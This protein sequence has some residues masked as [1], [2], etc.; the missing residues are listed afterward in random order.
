MM[1]S[2]REDVPTPADVT[3]QGGRIFT[4]ASP[5]QRRRG[6]GVGEELLEEGLGGE[7]EMNILGCK[8]D[9]LVFSVCCA[10]PFYYERNVLL[11]LQSKASCSTV[12]LYWLLRTAC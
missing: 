2:V 12:K 6:E 5:S 8:V 10:R 9:S 11:E 3:C 4:G 1:A 7:E